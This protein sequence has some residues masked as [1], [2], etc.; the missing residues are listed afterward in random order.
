MFNLSNN[1]TNAIFKSFCSSI[2]FTKMFKVKLS[3][4]GRF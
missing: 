2:K 4:A 3:D 1:A